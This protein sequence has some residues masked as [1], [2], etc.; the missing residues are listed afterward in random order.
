MIVILTRDDL[1]SR[2][3]NKCSPDPEDFLG[4]LPDKAHGMMSI[5]TSLD[6][7]RDLVMFRDGDKTT[8]F[9]PS[10]EDVEFK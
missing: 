4:V 6:G 9:F 3:E 2:A 10:S 7:S 8:I 5:D 1:L